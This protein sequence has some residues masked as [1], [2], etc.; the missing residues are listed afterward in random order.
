MK[1]ALMAL[2][3]NLVIYLFI[4]SIIYLLIYQ[5]TFFFF[6]WSLFV[7]LFSHSH[8]IIY[9]FII[10]ELILLWKLRYINTIMYI[11]RTHIHEFV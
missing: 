10:S 9:F 1:D 2:C 8:S 11:R 4:H 7:E 6:F 5:F 3:I